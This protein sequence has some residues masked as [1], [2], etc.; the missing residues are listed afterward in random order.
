MNVQQLIEALQTIQNKDL[1]VCIEDWNEQIQPPA[2]AEEVDLIL[3]HG[4]FFQSGRGRINGPYV[5]IGTK[6]YL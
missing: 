4:V 3:T 5:F 2:V 1:P 6:D